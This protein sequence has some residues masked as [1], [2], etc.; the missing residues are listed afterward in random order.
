[1]PMTPL[2]SLMNHNKYSLTR[3]E[4]QPGKPLVRLRISLSVPLNSTTVLTMDIASAKFEEE[5]RLFEARKS[6]M[7]RVAE[8]KFAV[9]KGSEFAGVFDDAAAAYNA[10]VVKY[11]NTPFLI[12]QIRKEEKLEQAPSLFL[13]SSGISGGFFTGWN[14]PATGILVCRNWLRP[15]HFS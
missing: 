15:S 13:A 9:I 8:G 3:G 14:C 5:L 4:H 12:K 6:E 1:M 7:L 2:Y 10:A 11:G